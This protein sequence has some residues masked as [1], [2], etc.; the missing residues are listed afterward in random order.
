M[1][2]DE[3]DE[4]CPL[5]PVWNASQS[6]FVRYLF[7]QRYLGTKMERRRNE[8]I[9]EQKASGR[10]G[11]LIGRVGDVKGL[12]LCLNTCIPLMRVIVEFDKRTKPGTRMERMS[13][14]KKGFAAA[15]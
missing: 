14:D 9:T 5:I 3:G 8:G 12:R 1:G 11:L 7:V 4:V 15:I 10:G 6:Y 13:A 2:A